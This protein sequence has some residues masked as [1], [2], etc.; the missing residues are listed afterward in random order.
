MTTSKEALERLL[1][2]AKKGCKV[3][4]CNVKYAENASDIIKKDLEVLEKLEK[5]IET[6][7][8]AFLLGVGE[9]HGVYY[10]LAHDNNYCMTK[11]EYDLL[12]GVLEDE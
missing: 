1:C 4:M 7:K 2:M 10:V 9:L 6:L 3:D 11:E 5:I 12:K 8:K